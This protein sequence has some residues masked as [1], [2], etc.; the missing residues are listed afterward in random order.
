MKFQDPFTVKCESCGHEGTY[1]VDLLL[2]YKANC[3]NCA[4]PF[5]YASDQMNGLIDGAN[6]LHELAMVVFGIE[7]HFGRAYESLEEEDFTSIRDLLKLME[8]ETDGKREV[9]TYLEKKYKTKIE[10]LD[11]PVLEGLGIELKKRKRGG[12][13]G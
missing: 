13:A 10:D 3:A 9:L 7:E 1:R 6:E 8:P 2:K 12:T 4:E 11:T 5:D